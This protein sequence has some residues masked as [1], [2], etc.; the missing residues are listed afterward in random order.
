EHCGVL[1]ALA[2]LAVELAARLPVHSARWQPRWDLAHLS[3]PDDHDDA[4]RTVA[5]GELDVRRL[6]RPARTAAGRPS[7]NAGIL[8]GTAS[9]RQGPADG[10]R[11]ATARWAD[12]SVCLHRLGLLPGDD[13]RWRRGD[14]AAH[15]RE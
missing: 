10:R 6:G 2:H 4:R 8:R 12:V 1:A 15:V 3:E 14:P 9:P 5:R 13:V 7:R 11:D